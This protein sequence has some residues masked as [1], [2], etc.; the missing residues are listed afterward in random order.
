MYFGSSM[1]NIFSFNCKRQTAL[2]YVTSNRQKRLTQ[3]NYVHYYLSHCYTIAWDILS[4]Q[5]LHS[6]VSIVP[7]G[8]LHTNRH[9]ADC[10]VARQLRVDKLLIKVRFTL[11]ELTARVD[12]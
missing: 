5:F 12:G 8:E 2:R 1:V 9:S 7:I 11:P 6:A 4:N 3:T 10:Y